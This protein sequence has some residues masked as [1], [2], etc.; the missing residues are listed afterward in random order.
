MFSSGLTFENF[1]SALPL[2]LW[3]VSQGLLAV[4]RGIVMCAARALGALA[5]SFG[6][7]QVR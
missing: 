4:H 7:L 2:V 5:E 6:G 1:I 3:A